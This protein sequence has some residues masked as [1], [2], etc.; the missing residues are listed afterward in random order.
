MK[1]KAPV[2]AFVVKVGEGGVEEARKSLWS[3]LLKGLPA[4]KIANTV[5][6]PR[7]DILVKPVD[8]GTFRALKRM[9]DEGKAVREES[10]RRPMIL[11]YDVGRDIEKDRLGKLLA[12]QNPDLG[13][14]EET[15]VPL[16]MKGPKTGDSV[17]WVCAVAPDAYQ[18]VVGKRV[19]LGMSCCRVEEFS[20][21]VR[22]FKCQRFGHRTTKCPASSDTC[23]KCAEVGHQAKDCKSNASRCANCRKAAPSA[24][25]ECAAKLRATLNAAR[26][27]DFGRTSK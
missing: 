1:A 5:T 13:I 19:Y 9:E 18:K 27:T 26:R 4:P 15:V 24:H 16:F 21:V 20:D 22:C 11:M 25:A 7:G 2:K 3:D 6:L 10:A 12:E 8:E 23:G 17:W 14:G